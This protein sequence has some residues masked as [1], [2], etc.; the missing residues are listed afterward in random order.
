MDLVQFY[1]DIMK[2]NNRIN[3]LSSNEINI[4]KKIMDRKKYIM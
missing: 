1:A 3:Y 2:N 4:S